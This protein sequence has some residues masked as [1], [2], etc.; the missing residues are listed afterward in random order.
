MNFAKAMHID[1]DDSVATFDCCIDLES[2]CELYDVYLD[3]AVKLEVKVTLYDDI[4]QL[5]A[6][7]IEIEEVSL[8][9][10]EDRAFELTDDDVMFNNI[11]KSEE[12]KDKILEEVTTELFEAWQDEIESNKADNSDNLYEIHRDSQLEIKRVK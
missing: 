10:G 2:S 8:V 1:L 9:F 11:V 6:S 3:Q 7:D 4:S 5:E 12:I